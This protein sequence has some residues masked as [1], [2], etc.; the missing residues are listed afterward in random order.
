MRSVWVEN[1]PLQVV[2]G[3]IRWGTAHEKHL[4]V[5]T[6]SPRTKLLN[7]EDTFQ[8]RQFTTS[9]LLQLWMVCVLQGPLSSKHELD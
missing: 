6:S 2:C 9:A 5:A 3:G 1:R 4:N 7:L 8:E